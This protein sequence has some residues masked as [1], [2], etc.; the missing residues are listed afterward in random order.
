MLSTLTNKE[1]RQKADMTP[2][3][4]Q[5]R[6]KNIKRGAMSVDIAT[7]KVENLAPKSLETLV[8]LLPNDPNG[9]KLRLRGDL[10]SLK[11]HFCV[12]CGSWGH[13]D[14]YCPILACLG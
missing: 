3:V 6:Q 14:R 8:S 2:K 13:E 9:P 5:D 1:D 10:E 12:G 4:L 11:G 7:P